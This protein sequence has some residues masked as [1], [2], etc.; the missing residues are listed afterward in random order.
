MN[1]STVDE[2]MSA[3]HNGLLRDTAQFEDSSSNPETVVRIS[4][5]V[6]LGYGVPT[7]ELRSVADKAS[8]K[9]STSNTLLSQERQVLTFHF[10]G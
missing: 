7:R 8:D 4:M 9:G 1:V 6:C 10:C 5:S 3:R 2:L